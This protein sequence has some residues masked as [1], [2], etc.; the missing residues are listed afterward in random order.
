MKTDIINGAFE[1]LLGR[2]WRMRFQEVQN[3]WD[4]GYFAV[5]YARH[6]GR[7]FHCPESLKNVPILS[8]W[9]RT[10]HL[11]HHTSSVSA[12]SCRLLID[13]PT[14]LKRFLL[15]SVDSKSEIVGFEM[16]LLNSQP[17][18][19]QQRSEILLRFSQRLLQRCHGPK[20]TDA[21]IL[22]MPGPPDITKRLQ[23]TFYIRVQYSHKGPSKRFADISEVTK[24]EETF[25]AE[26]DLASNLLH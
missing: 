10:K 7:I 25:G 4:T 21:C 22:Q 17:D 20:P 2:L 14:K 26:T 16:P 13:K 5:T 8:T 6:T 12:Q 1:R 19:V 24:I 9:P 18:T 23:V 15:S 11:L 3:V